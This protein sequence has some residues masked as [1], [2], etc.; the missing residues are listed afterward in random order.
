MALTLSP[1]NVLNANEEDLPLGMLTITPGALELF[2][3]YG[4]HGQLYLAYCLKRHITGDWG[5]V[6]QEDWQTNDDSRATGGR[7]L[8]SYILDPNMATTTKI[9]IITEADRSSTTILLP[10]EY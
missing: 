1:E 5:N 8:S 10:S 3:T 7:I 9:W 2:E 4:S 6:D